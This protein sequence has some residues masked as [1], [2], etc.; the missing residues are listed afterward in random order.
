VENLLVA[1][2]AQGLGAA[3]IS[4]SVFCPEVVT[5]TLAVPA[6]WQPLGAIAIGYPEETPKPRRALDVND[7]L[8][9]G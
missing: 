9:E 4:S 8:I 5:A 7:F 1:L 3:W 6:S 2:A